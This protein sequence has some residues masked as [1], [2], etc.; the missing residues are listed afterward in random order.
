MT[1]IP[2]PTSP[3]DFARELGRML[4]A[5][6]SVPSATEKIRQQAL[7]EWCSENW[8]R[9]RALARTFQSARDK[10]SNHERHLSLLG[11]MLADRDGIRTFLETIQPR[12][13]ADVIDAGISQ[14]GT[15]L[16]QFLEVFET[17]VG[18]YTTG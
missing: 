3:E 18:E 10:S 9:L 5:Q 15:R 11:D 6:K 1:R 8:Q 16:T 17:F 13:F 4:S 12:W 14:D 7:Q 2:V